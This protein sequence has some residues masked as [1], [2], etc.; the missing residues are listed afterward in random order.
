MTKNVG[1]PDRESAYG[2]CEN[3]ASGDGGDE[4]LQRPRRPNADTIS[5][6]RSL[7]LDA[8]NINDENTLMAAKTAIYEIRHETASLAGDE[9]GARCL[10][11]MA[12]IT[13]PRSDRASRILL[14]G[15]QGYHLHL[16]THRYGSHVVQTILQLCNQ[17]AGSQEKDEDDDDD[18]E[19]NEEEL[20]PLSDLI[21]GVARELT[22]YATQLA[23][24]VC[25][26]HVLRTLLCVLGGVEVVQ[27]PHQKSANQRGRDK[28]KKKKKKKVD[29]VSE[30]QAGGAVQLEMRHMVSPRI[31]P[32]SNDAWKD[33]LHLLASEL[34]LANEMKSNKANAPGEL[35]QLA[36]HPGAGPLLMV[37]I[38]V[39]TLVDQTD[40]NNDKVKDTKCVDAIADHRL[41]IHKPE[42][43]YEVG[44]EADAVVKRI[45]CWQTNTNEQPFASD[46]I[47]G[48]S[49]ESRGS[50]VLETILRTCPDPFYGSLLDCG[51]F[52]DPKS[53]SD[54]VEHDV[55][56]FVIQT[57]LATARNQE[58]AEA[59]M[60][61]C[62]EP[63]IA[64]GYV[65]DK[66]NRRGGVLWRATELAAKFRVRQEALLN[67]I[68]SGY[69]ALQKDQSTATEQDDSKDDGEKKKK[70]RTKKKAVLVDMKDC[71]PM[72]LDV[73]LPAKDGDRLGLDV[74]GARTV[75]HLLRFNPTRICEGTLQGITSNLSQ[76]QLEGIAKDG[77]GSRCIMDAILD[78]PTKDAAFSAAVEQLMERLSGR[79]V[80]LSVD[81]VGHHTVKKL[82]RALNGFEHKATFTAELANGVNRLGGNAMG[83]TIMEACAVKEFLEGEQVWKTA[84]SKLEEKENW[85]DD[86]VNSGNKEQAG[87][88]KKRKRKRKKNNDES[89]VLSSEQ[90]DS[91]DDENGIQKESTSSN[92]ESVMNTLTMPAVPLKKI[93]THSE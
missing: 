49:G 28:P 56:N 33:A 57:L 20:A 74:L 84:L 77:L 85:L 54:Y 47:F 5:Y 51:G 23:V 68:R 79:W 39:L 29:P 4:A 75:H 27:P 36:C 18:E 71:I 35:Q 43:L 86:I 89:K 17:A 25:G 14:T 44:S 92:V 76:E 83:R 24:H 62:I 72:L 3:V 91:D 10:E 70:I 38:R 82:F 16:A 65:L 40:G 67:S 66:S 81:R 1:G 61:H 63:L 48:L 45:L 12:R 90:H 6:V 34:T 31:D 73:K 37:L 7:P 60:V 11:T 26:S 93:R 64:S 30:A 13:V 9:L 42:P 21:L 88:V 50:H 22:P 46:V 80:G 58:Q 53:F 52:L 55:S 59:L 2:N 8:E 19:D 32:Q 15:L 78:G 69:G 87:G 41:G